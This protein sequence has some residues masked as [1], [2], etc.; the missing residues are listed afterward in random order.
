MKWLQERGDGSKNEDGI[1]PHR[2][3]CGSSDAGRQNEAPTKCESTCTSVWRPEP[4]TPTSNSNPQTQNLKPHTTNPH[5]STL[6]SPP[7][8]LSPQPS[9]LHTQHSTPYPQPSL[10]ELE[11]QNTNS[12]HKTQTP[13]P[14]PQTLNRKDRDGELL[15]DNLVCFSFFEQVSTSRYPAKKEQLK[16]GSKTSVSEMARAEARI[17]P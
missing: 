9:T 7:S 2:A 12:K 5:P 17:W 15:A 13:R 11:T 4:L 1:P 8:T 6:D 10:Q 16:R 3:L 14:K